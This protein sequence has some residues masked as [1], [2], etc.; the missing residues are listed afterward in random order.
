MGAGELQVGEDSSQ[1]GI[2]RPSGIDR[3]DDLGRRNVNYFEPGDYLNTAGAVCDD[4]RY[5]ARRQTDQICSQTLRDH[6]GDSSGSLNNVERS[7]DL[8][9]PICLEVAHETL[10]S[11]I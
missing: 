7:E 11:N 6:R 3:I 9:E 8:G 4:P 2:S 5:T 10:M 1:Q